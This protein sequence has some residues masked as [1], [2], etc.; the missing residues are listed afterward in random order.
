MHTEPQQEHRWLQKMVGDWDMEVECVMAPGEPPTKT[1]S[2]EQVK[3][4]GE[5][6]V[7]GE[8][9]GEMPGGGA[10]ISRMTL[11]YD[12]QKRRFVGTFVASMMPNLWLY[13]GALDAAG[14]VLTLDSEGPSMADD[15]TLAKYQ[16]ILEIKSN[17]HRVM[18]SRVLGADGQWTEFMTANY[19]LRT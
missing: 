14:K 13:D 2:F 11:G 16:D 10:A 3:P 1:T 8:G 7:L 18:R 5:F 6:W 12:P 9:E 15:G 17:G 19:R 4:I